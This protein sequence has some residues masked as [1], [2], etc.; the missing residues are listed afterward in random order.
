[1]PTTT[2]ESPAPAAPETWA[3]LLR[4]FDALG[5]DSGKLVKFVQRPEQIGAPGFWSEGISK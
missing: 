2:P 4:R 5:Y 3:D 1:M